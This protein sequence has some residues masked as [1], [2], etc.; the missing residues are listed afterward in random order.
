MVWNNFYHPLK[1][2][3]YSRSVKLVAQ[4]PDVSH[5]G[6]AHPGLAKAKKPSQY[7]T[8]HHMT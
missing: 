5:A 6:H 7:V 8:I 2:F 3:L 1:L 4:G